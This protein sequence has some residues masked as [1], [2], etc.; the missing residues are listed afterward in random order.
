VNPYSFAL[1]FA[2][3]IWWLNS[4]HEVDG[5]VSDLPFSEE[6]HAAQSLYEW[7]CMFEALVNDLSQERLDAE[8]EAWKNLDYKWRSLLPDKFRE[9]HAFAFLAKHP[10]LQIMCL[11]KNK[12]RSDKKNE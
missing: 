7:V 6:A 3:G 9:L 1:F 2:N 10:S 8:A 4:L 12:K 11:N 5:G